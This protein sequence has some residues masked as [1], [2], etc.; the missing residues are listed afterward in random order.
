MGWNSA[1]RRGPLAILAPVSVAVMLLLLGGPAFAGIASVSTYDDV[2]ADDNQCSLREA[3]HAVERDFDYNGCQLLDG[4][5]EVVLQPTPTQPYLLNSP[6]VIGGT[7]S[8]QG[9]GFEDTVIS[10]GGTVSSAFIVG[11]GTGASATLSN[12]QLSGFKGSAIVVRDRCVATISHISVRNGGDTFTDA[13]CLFNQGNT[14]FIQSE[15]SQLTGRNPGTVV[16]TGTLFISDSSFVGNWGEVGLITNAGG[17]MQVYNSTIARNDT[18]RGVITSSGGGYTHVEA[19]TIVRHHGRNVCAGCAALIA[20][21]GTL[22]IK[23]S[24]VEENRNDNGAEA[25]CA[26]A[27]GKLVSQGYNM[28]AS[29][30][31][32]CDAFRHSTDISGYARLQGADDQGPLVAGGLARVYVP[33]DFSPVLDLVPWEHCN[34]V[35]QRGVTRRAQPSCDAGAVERTSALFVKDLNDPKAGD[36]VIEQ[37]LEFLGFDV[38]SIDDNLATVT[39]ATGHAFVVISNSVSSSVVGATFKAVPQGVLSMEPWMYDEMGWSLENGG[40]TE[41]GTDVYMVGTR[42]DGIASNFGVMTGPVAVTTSAQPHGY[43][44]TDTGKAE[45]DVAAPPGWGVFSF[46]PLRELPDGTKAAGH[47]VAFFAGDDASANLTDAGKRL[48]DLAILRAARSNNWASVPLLSRFEAEALVMWTPTQGTLSENTSE[49]TEGSGSMSVNASGYT[50]IDSI[51]FSTSEWS[52]ANDQ[53]LLDVYV[54]PQGQPNPYYLGAVQMFLSVPSANI[55]NQYLGEVELTP[56]GTGWQTVTFQ[57][58]LMNVFSAELEDASFGIAVNTEPGAPP[59]SLD[60]LRFSGSSPVPAPTSVYDFESGTAGFDQSDGIVTSVAT[61]SAQAFDGSQCLAVNLNG[62]TDGRVWTVPGASPTPGST[63]SVRVFIPNG[64][65]VL[66]V[67]PYLM[68]QNWTW[69]D[70][71]NQ[72]LSHG[73]WVTLSVTVP[74]NAVLPLNELGL[75][76]YMNGSY[77][78]PIYVDSIDW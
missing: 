14:F 44:F 3:I 5:N 53:L 63:V 41:A 73:Q 18:A 61:S 36:A 26:G 22:E 12:L 75:K 43:G 71:W 4:P 48:L 1:T 30:D 20:T 47:R 77:Q 23:S 50:R 57:S 54:P 6:I 25:N 68:D 64:A 62:S 24:I 60:N 15:C 49:M 33:E 46:P 76:F 55:H 45:V 69:T 16:N 40:L 35:D 58:D 8:V 31:V 29:V 28:F 27:A 74:A 78:G 32:T 37:R 42:T 13:A 11:D 7:I 65:P 67:S 39:S 38:Q 34:G 21:D 70:S 2:V 56:G 51:P 19:S 59:V 66:S 72:S 9:A 10:G 17:E 52:D